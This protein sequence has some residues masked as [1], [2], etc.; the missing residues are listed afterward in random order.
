MFSKCGNFRRHVF[1]EGF[2]VFHKQDRRLK[3]DQQFLDLHPGD[4]VD[5]SRFAEKSGV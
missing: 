5:I 1:A 4:H 2:V 3:L